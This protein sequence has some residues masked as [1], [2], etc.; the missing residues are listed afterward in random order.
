VTPIVA[1]TAARDRA[2]CLAAGMN[3]YM[4]KPFQSEGIRLILAK[5]T[6]W[7]DYPTSGKVTH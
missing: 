2:E 5:W 1:T 3:D 7:E 6:L 4:P